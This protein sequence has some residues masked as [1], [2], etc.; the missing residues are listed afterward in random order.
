MSVSSRSSSANGTILS[1]EH[2]ASNLS[3]S[4]ISGPEKTDVLATAADDRSLLLP[5]ALLV[6]TM[7]NDDL[8]FRGVACSISLMVK[9]DFTFSSAP[10]S[11]S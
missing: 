8:D 7:A 3:K 11:V 1:C 4:L 10:M 6:G 2:L 9:A 5:A